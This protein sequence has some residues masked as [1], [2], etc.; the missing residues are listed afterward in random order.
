MWI[1]N[2]ITTVPCFYCNDPTSVSRIDRSFHQ[3][4]YHFRGGDSIN[5]IYY[6]I[7]SKVR[8]PSFF[9]SPSPYQ[10]SH[11]Q[12]IC[13]LD[14][15]SNKVTENQNWLIFLK[16][17]LRTISITLTRFHRTYFHTIFVVQKK[18]S[19]KQAWSLMHN[20]VIPSASANYLY[21]E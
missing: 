18:S 21:R 17:F 12:I 19:A 8:C 7:F 5:C 16:S 13:P 4:D 11:M 10:D 3:N 2:Y 15:T 14:P 6:T 9:Q 1:Y 20:H